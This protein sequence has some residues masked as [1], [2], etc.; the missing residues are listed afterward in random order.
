MDLT[1]VKAL[2]KKEFIH[3][4]RDPR[5]LWMAIAIPLLLL[6]LFG[7]ALTLDVDN[8]PLAVWDQDRTNVS[9]DF[10]L[11][12][13]NSPY[14]K[15]SG[16]F[17][18]YRALES[19]LDR[20]CAFMALV[21]DKDFSK[22]RKTSGAIPIQLLVDGSDS[23][24]ATIAIGYAESVILSENKK[25][26]AERMAASGLRYADPVDLRARVWFNPDLKSKNYIIPGLVAMIMMVIAGLLTSLTIAKEWE[27]GTM[28]QLISTPI[29]PL[30]LIFGKFTP[31]FFIGMLDVLISVLMGEFVFD[32]PF[33]GNIISLFAL[34][35]LFLTG[36]L[37]MGIF[38]SIAVKNQFI[39]SQI[40]LLITILPTFL[41]SGFAFPI[42]NMPIPIQVITYFIPA[43]YF[44]TILRGLYLKGTGL[45]V[46]YPEACCL[47]LFALVM[48]LLSVSKFRK[49]AA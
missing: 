22:S 45:G 8:V 14:F 28:E 1:R 20:G 9:R 41:L 44:I 18:N 49:K 13:H 30:E 7:F 27:N 29:T 25:I 11:N 3:V 19:Q 2:A 26:V 32:V 5:S 39:A 37:F 16:Y 24:T 10:L 36:A 33:R 46:L 35:A 4:M 6:F 48:V 43:K 42:A 34:S 47:V 17:N 15:V 38:I 23:N 40:A 12:F 21:I 31:Y